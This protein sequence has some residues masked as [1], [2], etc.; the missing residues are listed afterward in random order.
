VREIIALWIFLTEIL[1]ASTRQSSI[2]WR[3]DNTAALA[4]IRKEG[5]L[6]GRDLLEEAERILLLLHQRQLRILPALIPSEENV[7]ADVDSRF[8]LVPDWHLDPRVF[9]QILSL[10]GP[11]QIHLF[12]SLQSAQTTRFM[13]W[14][15]ADSPEAIDALGMRLDFAL[16]YLCPPIPLLKTCPRGSFS[17]SLRTGK[18]RLGSPVSRR[19]K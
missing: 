5:G 13:S 16:A 7:Q 14:R 19:F 6:K 11:P 8:Q 2:L 15:A 9:Q 10:W 18:P 3:I 17:L 12:A 4:H 1:P